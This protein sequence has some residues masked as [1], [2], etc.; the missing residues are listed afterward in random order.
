M[1][2][3][4]ALDQAIGNRSESRGGRKKKGPMPQKKLQKGEKRQKQ[5]EQK[6]HQDAEVS[7]EERL[8]QLAAF[9]KAA[10]LHAM[11]F[12]KVRRVVYSTCSIHQ[13]ENE[14]VVASILSEQP[15][16]DAA[17]TGYEAPRAFEVTEAMSG[18]HWKRRGKD[19]CGYDWRE[20]VVRCMPGEDHTHGFFVAVFERPACAVGEP[21]TS[22]PPPMR[23]P[24]AAQWAGA[25]DPSQQAAAEPAQDSTATSKEAGLAISGFGSAG[26]N[27][28]K[29]KRKKQGANPPQPEGHDAAVADED[30][31]EVAA[32]QS[33]TDDGGSECG[34]GG[35][36]SGSARTK[37]KNLHRR[38]Q[39]KKRKM[40]EAAAQALLALP[41]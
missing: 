26:G 3:Q 24:T 22:L 8:G 11:R 15:P 34:S 40:E 12:P 29:R 10:V 38:Q 28:K 2:A 31:D 13:Q 32:T 23:P 5:Q 39:K 7:P 20:K 25:S 21:G 6:H 9:Q 27:Q 33:A 17:D 14:D 4:S 37:K 1:T 41:A 19:D 36:G 35:G 16:V 30:D 18:L